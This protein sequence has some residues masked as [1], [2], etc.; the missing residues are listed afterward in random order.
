ME[1]SDVE[2]FGLK[3]AQSMSSSI[4]GFDEEKDPH[5]NTRYLFFLRQDRDR[6]MS[7][8]ISKL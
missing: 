8:L 4:E 7:L 2:F 1:R 6:E 5:R 3:S